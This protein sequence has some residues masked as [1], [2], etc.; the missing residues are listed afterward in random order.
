[1]KR[2]VLLFAVF[3]LAALAADFT[4][5]WSGPAKIDINGEER[6]SSAVMNLKQ[7]GTKLTGTAG[8]D[9][10]SQA[11]IQ[12]G[13]VNGDTVEFDIQPGDDAPVIHIKLTLDGET[14]RGEAN[15]DSG[16]NT[17]KA[18]LEFKRQK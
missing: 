11:P 15:G 4:G 13:V 3:S 18:K 9:D 5:K 7:D 2:L 6:D 10:Y 16:G 8:E 17:V 14:L 12:N 1:M